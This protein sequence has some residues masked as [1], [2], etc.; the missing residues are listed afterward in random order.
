MRCGNGGQGAP[1]LRQQFQRAGRNNEQTGAPVG[2]VLAPRND[3]L[4]K[5]VSQ[6]ATHR[7]SRTNVEQKQLF[8]RH[9]PPALFLVPYLDNDVEI[10]DGFEEGQLDPLEL[11]YFSKPSE[12]CHCCIFTSPV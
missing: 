10:D 4:V 11:P 2:R 12:Q 1:I 3:T 5:Q 9:G 8:D 6:F 7:G